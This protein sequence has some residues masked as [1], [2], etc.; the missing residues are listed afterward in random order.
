MIALVRHFG[1]SEDSGEPCGHCDVCAPVAR[2]AANSLSLPVPRSVS[3]KPVKV[4]KK[5]GKR[6]RRAARSKGVTLPAT[7]ASAELV[8]TLRAWRLT[9]AKRK[10]VPAFRIMTNR[11][12]LAVAE[13]RPGSAEALRNVQGVGP[14]LLQTYSAK[15]VELCARC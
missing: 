7:G 2:I 10:R 3:P 15:L 4:G 1:D 11:A 5:A 6:G 12:L 13:A 14:K 8:A 9:E